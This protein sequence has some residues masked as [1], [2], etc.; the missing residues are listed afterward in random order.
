MAAVVWKL[1]TVLYVLWL[2]LPQSSVQQ[3]CI[4]G[5]LV[6]LGDQAVAVR[7]GACKT[8]GT[9]LTFSEWRVSPLHRLLP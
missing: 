4:D 8:I 6:S 2:P 3:K 5:I 7:M 9:Y 1:L